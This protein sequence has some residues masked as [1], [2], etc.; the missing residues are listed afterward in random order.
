MRYEVRVIANEN[1]DSLRGETLFAGNNLVEARAIADEIANGD[2]QG[3]AAAE[4][5]SPTFGVGI[6]DTET[7]LIDFGFG[8]G[9]PVPQPEMD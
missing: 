6:K 7:G 4:G 9:V 1:C 8:F 5:I 3:L 2:P